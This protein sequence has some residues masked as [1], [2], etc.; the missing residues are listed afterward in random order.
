MYYARIIA[1]SYLLDYEG[2]IT[3]FVRHNFVRSMS[4]GV[5]VEGEGGE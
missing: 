4:A 3:N 2:G 1:T 5:R